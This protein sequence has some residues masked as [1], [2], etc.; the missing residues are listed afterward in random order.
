MWQHFEK[1]KGCV[2]FIARLCLKSVAAHFNLSKTLK[3]I[4]NKTER[5]IYTMKKKILSIM[6]TLS[7][8]A[9]FM[10]CI[11]SA[12]T[13][14]DFE[15]E[16]NGS[17]ITITKYDGNG[18]DIE[19]PAE[20]D[21]L[22][23]TEI[24][25]DAFHGKDWMESITIPDSVTTIGANAFTVCRRLKNV[26]I[27]DNVTSI[28]ESAFHG[29]EDLKSITIPGSV[30]EI[31][32]CAFTDCFSLEDVTILDGVT[33]ISDGMF[34]ACRSLKNITIPNSVT[35]IGS[36]AF[37]KC[38]ALTSITIPNSVTNISCC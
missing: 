35:S 20:I 1:V 34:W 37:H 5:K 6:L 29:C 21:G 27:P 23:V 14:G 36:M 9:M 8:L 18:G 19:I 32:K 25:N 3:K 17:G 11:A 7:M 12:E 16:S 28:G 24:G 31:G 2:L 33:I 10:P 13:Y 38:D 26:T 15:Y 22:P 4:K 30:K